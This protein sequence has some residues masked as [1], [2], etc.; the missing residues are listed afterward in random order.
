MLA[1]RLRLVN[2]TLDELAARA[3]DPEEE[4]CRM[5][6]LG[7]QYQLDFLQAAAR[8]RHNSLIRPHNTDTNTAAASAAAAAANGAA[9]EA[10]AMDTDAPAAAAAAGAEGEAEAGTA[11]VGQALPAAMAAAA[12]AAADDEPVTGNAWGTCDV[13]RYAMLHSSCMPVGGLSTE[14]SCQGRMCPPGCWLIVSAG[15]PICSLPR[16]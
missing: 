10:D 16:L 14:L 2:A 5:D 6:R 11:A 1:C 12:A 3:D 15:S 8:H 7:R 13:C 9:A 4:M